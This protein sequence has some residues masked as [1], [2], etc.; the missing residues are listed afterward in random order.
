PLLGRLRDRLHLL[1][2]PHKRPPSSR[3]PIAAEPEAERHHAEEREGEAQQREE[4]RG[5]ADRPRQEQRPAKAW[6]PAPSLPKMEDSMGQKGATSA[7][8]GRGKLKEVRAGDFVGTSRR[9]RH[10]QVISSAR[11]GDL[12]SA[13]RPARN[14][15]Q[16]RGL[17]RSRSF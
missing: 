4:H 12:A 7:N 16:C 15:D 1:A 5:E 17:F 8:F 14:S 6:S 9:R 2:R 3:R 10:G 13:N 11:T